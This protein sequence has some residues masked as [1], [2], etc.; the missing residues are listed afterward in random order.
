[1]RRAQWFLMSLPMVWVGSRRGAWRWWIRIS[2]DSQGR[3]KKREKS[4]E[5]NTTGAKKKDGR[6]NCT[7]IVMRLGCLASSRR[8]EEEEEEEG[9]VDVIRVVEGWEKEEDGRWGRWEGFRIDQAEDECSNATEETVSRIQW[10]W[11]TTMPICD[12]RC[13]ISFLYFAIERSARSK[14]RERREERGGGQDLC[15]TRPRQPQPPENKMSAREE[16]RESVCV[17]VCVWECVCGSV[18]VGVCVW[19]C[20]W[21]WEREREKALDKRR[22]TIGR[23]DDSSNRCPNCPL[24][25]TSQIHAWE[26]EKETALTVNDD[27]SEMR[28]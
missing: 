16:E 23:D 10:Q 12:W 19:E 14:R 26:K 9:R 27:W 20:V 11:T 25:C 17:G 13:I 15:R 21:V 22:T 6:N 7:A 18:C 28:L 2:D 24:G 3:T 4:K 1:M 5:R 8:R